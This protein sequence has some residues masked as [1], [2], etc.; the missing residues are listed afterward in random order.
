MKGELKKIKK[1]YGEDM[2]HFVRE[3][4]SKFLDNPYVVYNALTSL[5]YPNKFLYKD[6]LENNLLD[7]FAN[8][9]YKHL[10]HSEVKEKKKTKL[11]PYELM[12]KRGYTLYKCKNENDIE[13]FKKYYRDDEKLCTFK[14][15]RLNR[16]YVYFAVKKDVDEIKRED[17]DIP[18]RDD[19]YGT[20]VISIQINRITHMVSIKNRYNHTVENP[21]A[22]FGNNLDNIVPGL[23]YAFEKELGLK[24]D[25]SNVAEFEVPGYMKA[26]DGKYYKYNYEIINNYFCTD[27]VYIT[28]THVIG[29]NTV[30]KLDKS[31]Y[32]LID[33]IILDLKEKKVIYPYEEEGC[34]SNIGNIDKITITKHDNNKIINIDD[35]VI[36]EI[37]K[38]NNIIKYIDNYTEE[39]PDNFLS[40]NNKIEY[41]EFDKAKKIGINFLNSNDTVK[42][43]K[44]DNV[45][46]IDNNFLSYNENLSHINLP[47]VKIIKSYFLSHNKNIK[48]ITMNN[49]EEVGS[50]FLQSD[51]KLE[52]INLPNLKKTAC[53][54][55]EKASIENIYLPNLEET[56]GIALDNY[57]IKCINLPKLK[58]FTVGFTDSPQLREVHV[59]N[60]K[61]LSLEPYSFLKGCPK[62]E[63]LEIP[64]EVVSTYRWKYNPYY[65]DSYHY[66]GENKKIKELILV[67]KQRS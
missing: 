65:E 36:I 40:F 35:K 60:I 42:E 58:S 53:L 30:H 27:N 33:D 48:E 67:K 13:N 61:S 47:N 38:E 34:L 66:D 5:F 25:V 12:K 2:M 63:V 15:G 9:M 17:F 26:S 24:I 39:V 46:E 11:S 20:S 51:V 43:L 4:F 59:P 44:L 7:S 32:I 41:V 29:E 23:T 6:L 22:T 10:M 14:G 49:L 31:R 19:K 54:F 1:I 8:Y 28:D 37:D 21:D 57:F 16:C 50:S 62:V 3:R 55:L 56:S 64:E 18:R 45:R 52:K